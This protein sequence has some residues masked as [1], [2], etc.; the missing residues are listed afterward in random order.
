M[1]TA[2]TILFT[3]TLRQCTQCIIKRN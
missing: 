2:T 1:S 3:K